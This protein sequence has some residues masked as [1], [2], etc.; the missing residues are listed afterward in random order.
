MGTAVSASRLRWL[1]TFSAGVDH[2][3]F[4]S[5]VRRGVALTT[6]SGASAR[7]IA[8]S[9]IM[10]ILALSRDLPGWTRAQDARRWEP[11]AFDDIDG[12]TLGVVGMGPIGLEIGRAASAV[13]MDVLG[14]RRTPQPDDPWPTVASVAELA[15]LVDWLV[16]AAPLTDATRHMV[17]AGVLA[18][19]RPTARLVNIGRGALVDEVALLAALER[20]TIAGAALD[21]FDIEPLPED[22]HFWSMPNVIV[23]PHST[24]RSAGSDRRAT[25]IFLDNLARFGTGQPLRNHVTD[26]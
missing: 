13:G 20:R 18:S 26:L 15:P 12:T 3:V 17:D 11:H 7:P 24:G 21:V 23:T 14:C 10:L 19:M 1:H 6:S 8:H 9:A 22:H 4:A 25:A 2:P 5:F 16:L